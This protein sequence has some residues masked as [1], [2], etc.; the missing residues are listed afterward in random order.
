MEGYLDYKQISYYPTGT[1]SSDQ[2]LLPAIMKTLDMLSKYVS[3]KLSRV[4][5]SADPQGYVRLDEIDV[6]SSL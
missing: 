2:N 3:W 1:L 4:K 6:S 5:P